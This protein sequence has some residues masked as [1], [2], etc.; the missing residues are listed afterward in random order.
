MPISHNL[1][2]GKGFV[3][4]LD[5]SLAA[6]QLCHQGGLGLDLLA[7]AVVDSCELLRGQLTLQDAQDGQELQLSSPDLIL[8]AFERSPLSETRLVRC[9]H[10]LDPLDVLDVARALQLGQ[11]ALEGGNLGLRVLLVLL[12]V[13]LSA[14]AS[15][16]FRQACVCLLR[17]CT[18]CCCRLLGGL[19]GPN[20]ARPFCLCQGLPL[21]GGLL[22]VATRLAS[23]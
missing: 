6:Q 17:L 1:A 3:R 19:P 14:I 9:D 5:A 13:A 12:Q 20:R 21:L 23:F 18:H 10:V 22:A 16:P 2:V 7:D 11:L 8:Q 4:C 15:P